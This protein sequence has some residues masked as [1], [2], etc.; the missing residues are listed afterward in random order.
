MSK[1]QWEPWFL[2]EKIEY[3]KQNYNNCIINLS[4]NNY[5]KDN[6]IIKLLNCYKSNFYDYSAF[7]FDSFS[8]TNK[9]NLDEKFELILEIIK[10]NFIDDNFIIKFLET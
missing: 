4:N 3:L 1:K 6:E 9:N 5:T 8:E 2:N 7:Y 10:N